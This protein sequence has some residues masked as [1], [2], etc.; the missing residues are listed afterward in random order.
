MARKAASSSLVSGF[1][2]QFSHRMDIRLS[3]IHI[4]C[5]LFVIGVGVV[6]SRRLSRVV[7]NSKDDD[8]AEENVGASDAKEG[9]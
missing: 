5:M 7:D 1:L 2:C 8:D 9:N 6:D 4:S 3:L